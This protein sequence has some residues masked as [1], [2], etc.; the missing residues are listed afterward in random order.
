MATARRTRRSADDGPTTEALCSP[1]SGHHRPRKV[2]QFVARGSG[3]GVEGRCE[4]PL[5][6]GS[7]CA[8]R[9]LDLGPPR[10]EGRLGGQGGA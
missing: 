4:P 1:R 3:S 2:T 10:A 9:S 5:R 7:R 8:R 6:S